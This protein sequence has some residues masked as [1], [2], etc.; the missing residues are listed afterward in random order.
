MMSKFRMWY[1]E[2]QD[3]ITWFIIGLMVSNGL[4]HLGRGQ[5]GWAL[6]DFGIALLNFSLRRQRLS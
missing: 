2:H 1:I 5:F 6:F 4:M 3:A